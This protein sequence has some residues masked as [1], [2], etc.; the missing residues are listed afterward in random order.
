MPCARAPQ[1]GGGPGRPITSHRARAARGRDDPPPARARAPWPADRVAR[2]PRRAL[3]AAAGS[4]GPG[5]RGQRAPIEGLE[6]RGKYLLMRLDRGETLVMHLRMTG[7]LS[8]C[9]DGDARPGDGRLHRPPA[10]RHLRARFGSTTGASSG[11]PTRAA[12]GRRSCSAT[13]RS[14]SASA[15]GSG[16][17]RSPTSSRPRPSARCRGRPHG[18]AEVV[19][20][21]P[22]GGR[23]HRQHLRRRGALPC[24]AAP[25]LAGRLDASPS[26]CEAL[27][28]AIVE[29]L[30]AGIA[31]GGASID[32]YR[33]ARGE[34][35][36]MQ[37]E[38]LVHTREGLPCPRCGE[39][40]APDRRRRALDL[41]L[42]ALPGAAARAPAAAGG[43]SAGRGESGVSSAPLPGGFSVGHWSDPRRAT[44]CTVVIPP[45]GSRC[46]VDVRGGGPGTRETDV[47]GPLGRAPHEA[48]AVL[49]SGGS[50]FG[51]AAADGVAALARGARAR[52]PDARR[53]RADRPRG[54]HLRPGR[55]R[56][57]GPARARAGLRRLRGGRRGRPGARPG[58][59]RHRGRGRQDP[60]PR[61]RRPG[62]RRLRRGDDRPRRDGRRARG[63]QRLR[64]RPRR[65][66]LADRRGPRTR[67]ASRSPTAEAIAAMEAPPDWT[68]DRGAQHDPGLRPHRRR[69]RR[70]AP[71]PGSRGWRAPG[72]PAPSTRSSPTSTATSSSA[73]PAGEPREDRFSALAVGTVAATVTA[74]AIRD[75]VAPPDVSRAPH[76]PRRLPRTR[77]ASAEYGPPCVRGHARDPSRPRPSSCA[78]SASGRPTASSTSTRPRAGGSARSPRAR[79]GRA[80]A[81]AAGWS[82]SSA[83]TCPAR[84]PRRPRHRDLGGDPRRLPAP[85]LERPGARRR[86]AGV[87]RGPAPARRRRAQP[88]RLQPA[89]PLPVAARRPRR[90]LAAPEAALAFRLKLALA[91]GFSPELASCARC[92]EAEHLSGFSGAAGGVVC[93]GCEQG[94]FEIGPEAH[95]FMVGALGQPLA[96]APPADGAGASPGRAG[97]LRDARA[98]RAREQYIAPSNLLVQLVLR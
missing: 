87:R 9:D 93:A 49:L 70:A 69:A 7:N 31:G 76:V 48:S 17:S 92:G 74:A 83:S 11:S 4:G 40:I 35:G 62:R 52:A 82:R 89:L 15:A 20:A 29:A 63:R 21:R 39:P 32:D 27:R 57:R 51:L 6:R 38:F 86:G 44:G 42:P 88:P 18:A 68:Q 43:R 23:R 33:D 91:A 25:A 72:S 95:R 46:G 67:T 1:S 71:A 59:R 55:G 50:A 98:P 61:A 54:G 19:P 85:A 81:S 28:E 75:A 5:G 78:A 47:I 80:R 94:S 34:R 16:S 10:Q 96:E 84:G 45:P 36:A 64:R 65:G 14:R 66:R 60:R 26:I 8:C 2:G 37:D 77:E 73:S 97:G 24:P 41:L 58:R 90:G 30:E 22:G 56:P 3:V 53:D 79:G 13:R 12:S